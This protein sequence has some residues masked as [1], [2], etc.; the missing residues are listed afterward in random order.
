[1]NTVWDVVSGEHTIIRLYAF[2]Y[3]SIEDT[4]EAVTNKANKPTKGVLVVPITLVKVE[5]TIW[6]NN[7]S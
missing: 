7:V 5:D 1:M 2:G 6:P 3:E 4:K